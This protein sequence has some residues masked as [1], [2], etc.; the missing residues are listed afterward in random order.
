MVTPTHM[1]ELADQLRQ[2]L[3]RV[4]RDTLTAVAQIRS[5]MMTSITTRTETHRRIRLGKRERLKGTGI[6]IEKLEP[7]ERTLK[8][9]KGWPRSRTIADRFTRQCERTD[10]TWGAM[11]KEDSNVRCVDD[12][13]GKELPWTAVRR[14]REEELKFLR[15]LCVRES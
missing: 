15:D 4:T 11:A 7:M 5:E 2:K 14:A 8:H 9:Q 13:T 12:I 10:E 3:N 6:K 1:Q